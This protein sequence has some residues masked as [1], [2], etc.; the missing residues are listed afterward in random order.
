MKKSELRQIIKEE[1]EKIKEIGDSTASTFPSTYSLDKWGGLRYK[2]TT[3]S[4]LPYVVEIEQDEIE[5][6]YLEVDFHISSTRGYYET[7][8]GEL[9]KIMSTLTNIIKSLVK[10]TPHIKG[11]SY[12]PTPKLNQKG[13]E[14]EELWVGNQRDN[15]YKIYIKKHFPQVTFKN[16]NNKVY[17]QF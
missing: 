17:A 13:K 8:K 1:M 16:I 11:L 10:N 12:H 14:G 15:L 6:N 7:N 4:G 5:E 3:D 9:F 2:F